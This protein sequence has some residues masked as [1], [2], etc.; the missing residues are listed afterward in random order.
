MTIIKPKKYRMGDVRED[1]MVFI[2]YKHKRKNPEYWSTPEQ[3]AKRL[4]K[5]RLKQARWAKNNKNKK[6]QLDALYRQNNK[7][8]LKEYHL[9]YYS[10]NSEK[11]KQK[12]RDW[13]FA[14]QERNKESKKIYREKNKD[15]LNQYFLQRRNSDHLFK[16]RGDI[17]NLI[18]ISLRKRRFLKKNRTEEILG[19]TFDEF[20][21]HI[22]SQFQSGMNWENRS[23]WHIDHIVPLASAETEEEILRLNHHSNLR[24]LWAIDNLKKGSKILCQFQ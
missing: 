2:E 24:P 6:R 16:M 5:A 10:K 1:G 22:E 17:R 12:T 8:K 20:L 23:E 7:Q 13:N 3:Y 18:S 15:K 9:E 4:E 19:C 14:N 21:N 11:L